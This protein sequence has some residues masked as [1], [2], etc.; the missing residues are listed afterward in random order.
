MISSCGNKLVKKA[1]GL[2]SEKTLKGIDDAN[3]IKRRSCPCRRNGIVKV[4][5]TICGISP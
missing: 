2:K 1:F 5:K 4:E 3:Y